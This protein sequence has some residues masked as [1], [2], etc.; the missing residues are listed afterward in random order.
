MLLEPPGQGAAG[1]RTPSLTA[2]AAETRRVRVRVRR[3]VEAPPPSA[4]SRIAWPLAAGV[5]AAFVFGTSTGDAFVAA[6]LL[7][8]AVGPWSGAA[9]GAAGAATVAR[10][11]TSDLG[12]VA[13]DQDVLGPA[14]GT[15][16]ALAV[17]SSVLA[18]LAVLVGTAARVPEGRRV[19]AV[20]AAGLGAGVLASGPAPTSAA[21]AGAR[22]AGAAGGLV[23]AWLLT[24]RR[25]RSRVPVWAG[26]LLGGA[27]VACA[28]VA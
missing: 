11:G 9:A 4:W 13:G 23:L 8:L 20:L 24:T 22:A 18:A 10:W 15:G 1:R 19:V 28:V 21:D 27:A 6:A 17:A 25:V 5:G 12:I 26:A 16:P 7:G 14:I 2:P 3:S